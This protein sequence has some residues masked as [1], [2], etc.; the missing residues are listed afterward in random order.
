[1]DNTAITDAAL[2]SL[3]SLENLQY[4][5]LY[6]TS[7]SD[8]GLKKLALL[9]NLKKLFLW[10]TKVT[11]SGVADL[12]KS[13]PNTAIYFETPFLENEVKKTKK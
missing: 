9:K 6:N 8:V 10:Q 12:K 3:S 5:N 4:L 2:S 13:L 11:A 1:M 7:I